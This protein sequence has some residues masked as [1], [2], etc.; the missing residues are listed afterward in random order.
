MLQTLRGVATLFAGHTVCVL[1]MPRGAA[2]TVC[3]MLLNGVPSNGCEEEGKREKEGRGEGNP[4]L[5]LSVGN[6]TFPD[7]NQ[8]SLN[9]LLSH[10]TPVHLS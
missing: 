9:V 1:Q 10:S 4:S 3:W 7:V 2:N 5:S 6:K 8:K